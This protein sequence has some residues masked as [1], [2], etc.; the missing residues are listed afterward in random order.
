[1]IWLARLFGAVALVG[2]AAAV[3]YAGPLITFSEQRILE[4][5]EVRLFVIGGAVVLVAAHYTYRLLRDRWAQKAL[6]AAVAGSSESENDSQ[7][8]EER[9]A[10]AIDVLKTSY[11]RRNF[12]YEL[13]WY[14]II[15]P[16]GAGKTT[17]LVNSGLSFPLAGS[18][19]AQPVA[20]VGGTRYCDW[21]FTEEAVLIDTAGRYTTHDSDLRRDKTSW[22]AFLGS[23]KRNRP[24][25]PV[26]G[27]I[28]AIS[29]H[30]LMTLN[31]QDLG[32]HVSEIRNR[33]DEIHD[34][35]KVEFPVYVVFTKADLVSGFTEYF[36][37]FDET[38][39]RQ[40]WGIT[41]QTEDRTRNMVDG[42]P[43]GFDSLVARLSEEMA[44]RLSEEPDPR[45]RIAI[46]GFPIQF[47]SLRDQITKFL[48]GVF[49]PARQHLDA[50]LRGFYFSS[51]TQQGTPI[52]Q[53]LGSMEQT[54]DRPAQAKMSGTGRSYFLHD[55]LHQVIFPEAGWV[56]SD[57]EAQRRIAL[58]RYAGFA[59]VGLAT[60][61][62]LGAFGLS[63]VGNQALIA[64]TAR[65][66][67]QYRSEAAPHLAA[68]T[69]GDTDLENIIGALDA[70][71]NL[72]VGYGSRDEVAPVTETF[73]LS[74]SE[75]LRSASE[76]AYRRA[77]ERMLRPRLLLELEQAID[78]AKADA[79]SVYEPLK[80]YLMLGGKAPKT[81]DE[82][83]VS[84]FVRDWEEHRYP[85]AMNRTGRADLE[86]HLR[87]MLDLDDA[88]EL[89]YPLNQPLIQ[90]AQR[91]LNQL[92]LTERAGAIVRS[93]Y[94]L[95]DQFD[96]SIAQHAGSE[97]QLVLAT[98]DGSSLSGLRIPGIYTHAGFNNVLLDQLSQVARKV[99][100]DRWVLG[101]GGAQTDT[102]A[103]LRRVGPELVEQYGKEF[104]A[105]WHTHLD[106][107]KLRD[108]AAD[109]P[110]YLAL[111]SVASS[112]SPITRLFEAAASEMVLT[113]DPADMG[114]ASGSESE[115]TATAAD[116]AS[117][118]ARI[119]LT[120]AA[121]KSQNRA[122]IGS[123]ATADQNPVAA[124]EA[125]LR[126]FVGMVSG[127]PGQRPI[128]VLTRNFSDI[129]QSLRLANMT[130]GQNDRASA[131]LRLQISNL[132]TNA[133]RLPKTLSRI[134]QATAD[135]FEGQ[136]IQASV[137]QLNQSFDRVLATCNETIANRYP[138]SPDGAEDVSLQDFAKMFAPGGL[139]D[140]FF[141][142]DLSPLVDMTGPSWRWK[143]DASLGREFSDDSLKQFQ[144]ASE[145]RE[146]FFPARQP[147]PSIQLTMTPF[148]LHGEA[149]M[150][151]LEVDGQV[152]ESLHSGS[153][154]TRITWPGD[155][156]G[157]SARLSLSPELPGRESTLGFEGP[158]AL[159]R[160][161]DRATMRQSGASVE[162]RFL[163][164]GRDVAYVLDSGTAGNPFALPALSSFSCPQSL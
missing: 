34:I 163:I 37:A 51:G 96:F 21:W 82:L 6:E 22:L 156:R 81:D 93:A 97:A 12:L 147:L 50:S 43:S 15:G 134:V 41:F 20:G 84:W 101:A 164:G 155:M 142:R 138:F 1:M 38:R 83:V 40:V 31:G 128:D 153:S 13:P 112:N 57:R 115:A 94:H 159:K 32:A 145:I 75:R 123:T 105:A 11:V 130:A 116:R 73:G 161:L 46:F 103:D 127:V 135:E 77:L 14:L 48:R 129:R 100:E 17:A 124:I 80:I 106:R 95:A 49:D 148:S 64:S 125:Q 119:G 65:S 36:S 7:V 108:L 42:A 107:L 58:A 18:G 54:F 144:L 3:W 99:V 9:M 140:L 111:S 10:E 23:L 56:S 4:G 69:I 28:L 78:Q 85:G 143:R 16:P 24:S 89:P 90:A 158:W 114:G 25:Q 59:L 151:L 157:G 146:A 160:L 55:L 154:P 136:S 149:D 39:R 62:P 8:L 70:V 68:A 122:G 110:D 53:L 33:L 30:D 118:L 150:A 45:A 152:A 139:L 120:F 88:Y 35:L 137:S 71:R 113:Q 86:K 126:P 79:G 44:A 131:N 162:L 121:S 92:A 52:D 109:K 102:D 61:L 133:S 60:A 29:L 47:A 19:R 72:P 98:T 141:A 2:F 132:R 91:S 74:Q 5:V 63:Y 117:G 66:V 27:V 26:N 104:V 76:T 87:A 67:E